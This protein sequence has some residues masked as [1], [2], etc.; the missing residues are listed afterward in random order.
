MKQNLKNT[1]PFLLML[2]VCQ[3]NA[4]AR[5]ELRFSKEAGRYNNAMQIRIE[6]EVGAS[7]HYTTDGNRPSRSS[8][9]FSSPIII[10]KT[11]TVQAVAFKNNRASEIYTNTYLIGETTKFMVVAITVE[12]DILNN[13]Q[14]GWLHKGP[15]ADTAYPYLNANYWTRKEISAYLEIFE[16]DGTVVFSDQVGLSLFGGMSRTFNQKSFAVSTREIYGAN[17]I[18]YPIFPDKKQKKYKHLVIR[19]SGSDCEKAHFRDPFM[20]S[21]LKDIDIEKQSYRPIIY[22][23]NG[24][25]WGIYYLRDKVNPHFVGYSSEHDRDSI[26]FIEQRDRA[27][28]GDLQHYNAMFEYIG[29]QDLSKKEHYDYIQTQMEVDN[30][31][32]LQVAQIYFDNHDAG[33][34]IKFWRP[35]TPN[36][37][38]RW[39]LYDTDWGFGLQDDHAYKFNTLELQTDPNSTVWPNPQW[40]T[41]IL[42]NLLKNKEFESAFVNRMADYMNTIFEPTHVAVRIDSFVQMLTPEIDRHHSRWN[43]SKLFWLKHIRIMHT[44]AKERPKYM[45][46]FL[47]QKFNIGEARNFELEV[48]EGGYVL[49]NNHTK[50]KKQLKGKYFEKVPITLKAIPDYGYAFSH[51]ELPEGKKSD[52]E[53]VYVLKT[54]TNQVK[55]V[56]KVSNHPMDRKV[57]FNEISPTNKES[58]DWVELFN[59]SKKAINMKGWI[60][61]DM[62]HDFILPNVSIPAEGYLILSQDTAAFKSVFPRVKNVV[63][64]FDFGLSKSKESLLLFANNGALMDSVLYQL[65]NEDSTFTL[66]L[67]FP[68]MDNSKESDW[69]IIAGIGTPGQANPGYQQQLRKIRERQFIWIGVALLVV[70]GIGFLVFKKYRKGTLI[71]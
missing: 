35:K 7:I 29:K 61:K 31:L 20:T 27:K 50:I 62:N 17:R 44:F 28:S 8:A 57:V 9:K 46:Q 68:D 54:N 52:K 18:N 56:F 51:W 43:Y 11:T 36:G 30:F 53:V 2:L 38:W 32:T 60:F 70:L 39:V 3:A 63:G 58:G 65:N 66:S 19:N 25:Y 67:P 22:Y 23:V 45:I 49:V 26:D 55:A 64:N 12:P 1:L 16:S 33:G 14:T 59:L 48:N 42:R 21:L 13:P 4:Q 10:N 69:S 6:S 34:N 24:E 41:H 40:S 37:R 15:N 47:Q 5:L 71:G